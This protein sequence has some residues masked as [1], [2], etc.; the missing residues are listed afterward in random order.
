MGKFNNLL[1]VPELV[2]GRA[3]FTQEPCVR[4]LS[5]VLFTS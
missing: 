4:H 5:K 1:K 3:D 2:S